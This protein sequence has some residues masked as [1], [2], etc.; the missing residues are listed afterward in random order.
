VLSTALRLALREI[1]NH[2]RFAA[3][4]VANLALGFAGFVALD[5]FE[6]SISRTLEGRSQA[7]L[8]ADVAVTSRRPLSEAEIRRLDDIAGSDARRAR[9]VQLF[10]M[11]GAGPAA[12]LVEL[13]AIDAAYPL[14]GA[15]ALEDGT[16]TGAPAA[17]PTPARRALRESRGAWIDPAL[18]AQLGVRPG[19]RLRVGRTDFR[20]LGFVDRD[21]GRA[22][23]GFSIAPRVYVDLA[24]LDA[25]GLVA[26]GS[27][28]EYARLY[29]LPPDAEPTAVARSMRLA[30][31]DPRT[32]A[33]SHEEETRDL[34]RAYERVT[35]YLGLVA[36]VAIFLA[37]LGAAHLFRAQLGRRVSDLAILLS[38]GATRG[39]AQA[40]FGV[41]LALLGVAAAGLA[42]ALGA[43]LLPALASVAGDLTP[44][45][46]TPRVGPATVATVAG[47]ATLG[48][49][50]ACLPLVVRLRGL[51]PAE[52]FAEEAR[53][54]LVA[55]PREAWW[56]TPAAL[57]FWGLA[58][59]RAD[60]LAVGSAFAGIFGAATLVLAALGVAA[61]RGL[62]AL[63][64]RRGLAPRLAVRALVRG[65]G[66]TLAAFVSLA[67][68][69]LLVGLVLEL[70]AVLARDLATSPD[71]PRPSLFLFDIQP[72][73]RDALAA[74]VAARGTRLQRVS[75]LVRARLDHVDGVEVG[76]APEGG[77]PPSRSRLARDEAGEAR[78]LRSRRYNLTWRAGLNGSEILRAGRPFSGRWDPDSGAPA[79]LSLE[80]DFAERLGVGLGDRLGFDVQ[81]VPVEGRVV[82]LRE[83][84]WQSFQPNFFVVFQPGVLE[85]APA[86][87]L[88]SVPALPP[89]ARESLQASIQVAFPNVSSIDVTQAVRRL[90]GLVGQLQWA[91]S[92][93][94]W[95]SLGVGW[96]L[97]VALARDAARARRWETNLLKVLGAEPRD[98]R[99]ALDLEFAALGTLAALCGAGLG[100]MGAAVL[101]RVVLEQP[102]AAPAPSLALLVLGIP[103]SC[104]ATARG[105]CRSVLRERPLALLQAGAASSRAAV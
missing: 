35:R 11:A 87:Y 86:V 6:R 37:G 40:V 68:C 30:L 29:R 55:G 27:R 12:R 16:G 99:R 31:D 88:A 76:A 95:L 19:D 34:A 62:E 63:P 105:A 72:D 77:A 57:G 52:L 97:V 79:E 92:G 49:A 8:G 104:A 96:L 75:P 33:R 84:R 44:P 23:S 36:L 82:S 7:F 91:L 78:R 89:Q 41:Q 94:A 81:G 5:A 9:S 47:L 61:L 42:S 83:V 46:F 73:Q 4:F 1:R 22:T 60:S 59:W 69:A 10:S 17:G 56:W 85:A 101:A 98:I 21:G 71:A 26:T 90:E 65:R 25:T 50:A 20:V 38:L 58:C 14:Y 43:L 32:R 48:S 66:R 24:H 51:R 39:L 102:A 53:P 54:A 15:I 103:L 13:R 18:E 100:A 74:H 70:R 2:P 67:L 93:A 64:R 80:I 3:F 28:V 45:G